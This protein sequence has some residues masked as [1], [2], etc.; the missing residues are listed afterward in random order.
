MPVF[1]NRSIENLSIAKHHVRVMVFGGNCA[2][3]YYFIWSDIFRSETSNAIKERGN[4][5]SLMDLKSL[6]SDPD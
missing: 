4:Q 3:V 6:A 5:T 1:W 2:T